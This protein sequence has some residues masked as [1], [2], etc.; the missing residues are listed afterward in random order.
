MADTVADPCSCCFCAQARARDIAESNMNKEL[1][2]MSNAL[3]VHTC[4]IANVKVT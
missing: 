3:K 4:Y 2:S 1:Q